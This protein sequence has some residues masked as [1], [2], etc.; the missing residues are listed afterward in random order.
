[1]FERLSK[2]DKIILLVLLIAGIGYCFYHFLLVAQFQAYEQVKTDLAVSQAK[3]TQSI[4]LAATQQSESS[5]LEK[6]KKDVKEAGK[7][8]ETEM[9]DGSSVIILGLDGIFEGVDITSLEPGEI[10]EGPYL[11][12]MP[13]KIT[14]QGNYR[15][16]LSFCEDIENMTNITEVKSLK[17]ESVSGSN[18]VNMTVELVIF[19]AKTPQGRLSLEDVS[20]WLTGRYNIFRPSPMIA[21]IPELTGKI[22]KPESPADS[23]GSQSERTG[24]GQG[25]ASG[26]S[27]NSVSPQ[28]EYIWK[29]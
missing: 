11:L 16:M 12:E 2:R 25:S 18:K 21:P 22:I 26:S 19:S 6:A 27:D 4:A 20:R 3:L 5:K 24:T 14:A 1:M 15:E 23:T 8:F 29:K 7:R 10:K 17:M 28:P 9:R 13:M